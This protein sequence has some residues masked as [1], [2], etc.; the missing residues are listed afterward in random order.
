MGGTVGNWFMAQKRAILLS[1]LL[2]FGLLF[3]GKAL[4][5]I[6]YGSGFGQGMGW[7]G[8]GVFYGLDMGGR[9]MFMGCVFVNE[10]Y[11]GG[12]MDRWIDGRKKVYKL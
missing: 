9:C 11:M 4:D 10:C 6:G 3:F 2:S 8:Y 7:V 1:C 5:G 12:S